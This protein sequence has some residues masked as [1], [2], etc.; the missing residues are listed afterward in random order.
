MATVYAQATIQNSL[1]F[2]Y[3]EIVLMAS[4]I[5]LHHTHTHTHNRSE[6]RDAFP[7]CWVLF[8]P[9]D[10]CRC[11]AKPSQYYKVIMLQLQ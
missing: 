11:M 7:K 6:M 5:Y 9:Q 8:S 2:S 10:L 4:L 1:S 3:P